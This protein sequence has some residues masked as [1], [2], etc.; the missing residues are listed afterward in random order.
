MLQCPDNATAPQSMGKPF[1]EIYSP[2]VLLGSV[3][4]RGWPWTITALITISMVAFVICYKLRTT[5]DSAFDD[6]AT[7][8]YHAIEDPFWSRVLSKTKA[9]HPDTTSRQ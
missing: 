5:A 2:C 8:E 3:T 6:V 4:W 9:A 1:I 7:E